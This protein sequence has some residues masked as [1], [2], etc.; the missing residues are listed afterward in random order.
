MSSVMRRRRGVMEKLLCEMGFVAHNI[1]F[2]SQRRSGGE[3]LRL[4][5]NRC[6]FGDCYR[7]RVPL[8]TA[9]RFSPITY[10][11]H[12]YHNIMKVISYKMG[13]PGQRRPPKRAF[14]FR[15]DAQVLVQSG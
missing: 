12:V 13:I 11:I 14:P 8:H 10:T 5:S 9:K 6:A 2:S 1:P 4:D 7:K 3:R 15:P